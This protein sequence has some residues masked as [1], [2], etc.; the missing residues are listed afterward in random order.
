M[1]AL[2]YPTSLLL[3][4]LAP[5]LAAF[6]LWRARRDE[7]AREAFSDKARFAAFGIGARGRRAWLTPALLI[8]AA[9]LA[10]VAIARPLGPPTGDEK[11]AVSMDVIIALDVSDSMA[12]EDVQGNRL[13]A[14]KG[15]IK[16]LVMAAPNNRYGLVLFSG[17]AVIT[18]P[19]TLD[20]DTLLNFVEDADFGRTNL[21]GTAIGEALLTAATKF[22]KS[23]LPRA[24][25][26]VT[27][28]EN[29]YGADPVKAAETAKEGGLKVMTVGVGSDAGGRIPA[30]Y[31]F[32][33]QVQY[34]RDSDGNIVVSRLDE[35][36]LRK[37]ADAGGGKYFAA[38]E[39][40]SVKALARELTAKAK[41]AVRDPF[42]GAKEYGPY[43]ALAAAV[44]VGV[45]VVL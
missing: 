8:S 44:L 39:H 43:F 19:P 42:R 2:G 45:A 12:V 28:G 9:A 14:A 41:K 5:L 27:D 16:R 31:D 17:D 40:G 34:K 10:S 37:V 7:R 30:S 25:V 15:Y 18:C 6:Y 22:K 24:V 26:V 21:P 35:D 20:H 29:T 1:T 13:S 23:D 33:G 36:T 32:F 3:L 4:L 11:K 38:S